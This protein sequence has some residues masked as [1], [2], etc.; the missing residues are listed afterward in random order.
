MEDGGKVDCG[1]SK[2]FDFESAQLHW[3]LQVEGNLDYVSLTRR[4]YVEGPGSV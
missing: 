4:Y 1:Q 3:Q 2:S